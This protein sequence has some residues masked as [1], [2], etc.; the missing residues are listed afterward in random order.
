MRHADVV[1]KVP[2]PVIQTSGIRDAN[3]P[4]I[5]LQ[6]MP[7]TNMGRRRREVCRGV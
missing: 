5:I 4:A 3:S 7:E 6:R 2:T 1:A